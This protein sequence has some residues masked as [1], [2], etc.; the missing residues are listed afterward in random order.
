VTAESVIGELACG[1]GL[2]TTNAPTTARELA[3]V[4][5]GRDIPWRRE[6]WPIPETLA[7]RR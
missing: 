1:L 3:T 4:W 5:A 6:P 2:A 7:V